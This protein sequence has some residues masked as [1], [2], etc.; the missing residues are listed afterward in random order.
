MKI[1]ILFITIICYCVSMAGYSQIHLQFLN[2]SKSKS[3]DEIVKRVEEYYKDKDKGPGSGYLQFKRWEY[4]NSTR[5]TEDG[6]VLDVVNRNFN[7]FYFYQ[8]NTLGTS[9]GRTSGS[10]LEGNWKAVGPTEF[11]IL[12]ASS[13]AGL[14]RV[15]AIEVDPSNSN[16]IYVGTPGGGLWRTKNGGITWAPL[17]DG[18]PRM[19]ISGIAIDYTSPPSN[20][21]IY[22]LT[23]DGDSDDTPS[24]GVLKSMDNGGTWFSTGLSGSDLQR[25]FKLRIHPTNPNTL[26]VADWNG[27]FKTTDGGLSWIKTTSNVSNP[28]FFDV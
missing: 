28:S 15:N 24:V 5:L 22:I 19:G 7:E 16:I 11:E 26:F 12:G 23:G 14:G 8:Q 3:F 25:S 17:T 20:R 10:G 18:I 2:E 6:R 13:S 27:I 4:H 1:R 9:R 21:T